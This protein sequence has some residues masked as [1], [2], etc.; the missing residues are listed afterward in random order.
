LG[1][2]ALTIAVCLAMV[3]SGCGSRV[4]KN[5]HARIK[6]GMTEAEVQRILGS[7][8]ETREVIDS[9]VFG[10]VEKPRE[11]G[12]RWREWV[13]KSKGLSITLHLDRQ[14]KVTYK[15]CSGFPE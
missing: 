14:G 7:P 15:T 5:N 10:G 13:W 11:T 6:I 3:L 12:P 4:S 8:D 2:L 1:L 9:I